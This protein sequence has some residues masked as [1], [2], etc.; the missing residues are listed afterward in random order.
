MYLLRDKLSDSKRRPDAPPTRVQ[1]VRLRERA[2]C[3]EARVRDLERQL[4]DARAQPCD[5]CG[6][7]RRRVTASLAAL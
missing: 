2:A 3:L 7:K 1:V 5:A 4:S 6:S